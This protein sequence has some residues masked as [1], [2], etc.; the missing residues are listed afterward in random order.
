MSN[1]PS[2]STPAWGSTASGMII[3]LDLDVPRDTERVSLV[4]WLVTGVALTS[5]DLPP[6]SNNTV[7]LTSPDP[8][9]TYMRPSPPVGDVAHSY[10]FYLF[11]QPDNFALPPKYANL[12]DNRAPFDLQEF[13]ADAGMQESALVASNY[14]RARNL[15]G[16][17][18]TT[19]PPPRATTVDLETPPSQTPT[20][21][22]STGSAPSL[23]CDKGIWVWGLGAMSVGLL[24]FT[25]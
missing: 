22:Q 16:H 7:L 9:V 18:T 19:F 20:P 2:V 13:L 4:H 12:E 10:K 15:S 14:F 8:A 17:P 3:M 11:E 5:S 23:L 21:E 25:L 6:D 24:S 1:I